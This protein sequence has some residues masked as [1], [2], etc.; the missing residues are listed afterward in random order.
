MEEIVDSFFTTIKILLVKIK[1]LL[2]IAT[3]TDLYKD[4]PSIWDTEYDEF[5]INLKNISGEVYAKIRKFV[6]ENEPKIK[7]QIELLEK[8]TIDPNNIDST[9]PFQKAIDTACDI[10]KEIFYGLV[11]TVV[12]SPLSLHVF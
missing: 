6:K 10:V 11:Y 4:L 2:E 1:D 7:E 8:I 3:E 5:K 9:S 12:D